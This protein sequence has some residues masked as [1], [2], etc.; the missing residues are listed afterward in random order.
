MVWKHY[1]NFRYSTNMLKIRSRDLTV[2][3]T[4]MLI[5]FNKQITN[6]FVKIDNGC[7]G[8]FKPC[9][10]SEMGHFLRSRYCLYRRT[11]NLV[12]H[13]RWSFLQKF[14]KTKSRSLFVQKPSLFTWMFDKVLNVLLNLLPK[15]KMFHF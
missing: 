6:S 5:K 8:E 9:Q 13:L 12:K 11:Q 7:K 15:L 1:Y 14:S 10:T 4:V 3:N 2:H